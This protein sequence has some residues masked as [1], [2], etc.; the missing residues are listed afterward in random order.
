[1]I[2]QIFLTSIISLILFSC[3]S[4][5]SPVQKKKVISYG[6]ESNVDKNDALIIDSSVLE[7][8]KQIN[9]NNI[10]NKK[11]NKTIL[12]EEILS[13]TVF[14]IHELKSFNTYL[15]SIEMEHFK[16]YSGEALGL[17]ISVYLY[18]GL[19]IEDFKWDIF[20]LSKKLNNKSLYSRYGY[21]MMNEIILSKFKTLK[22]GYDNNVLITPECLSEDSRSSNI[23]LF[24]SL[25]LY[26]KFLLSSDKS[27]KCSN[28]LEQIG[29]FLSVNN[30]IAIKYISP[31]FPMS[32][33]LVKY[34]YKM[35]KHK[36][37]KQENIK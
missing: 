34:F 4:K 6:I 26:Y 28:H 13:L 37:F 20:K 36:L 32:G 5:V 18:Q 11:L 30:K 2:N 10:D 19:K 22:V 3:S 24:R 33:E 27:I 14:S 23:S 12:N 25:Q 35:K 17:L 29:K 9:N 31:K 1:M 16:Y 8:S 15:N 7:E 21:K